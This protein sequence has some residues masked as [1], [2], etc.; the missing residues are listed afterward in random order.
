MNVFAANDPTST[1]DIWS[2]IQTQIQ[3]SNICVF[4]NT[5]NDRRYRTNQLL[6]LVYEKMKPDKLIVRGENI[7]AQINK[8][9]QENPE[10][11]TICL[12]NKINIKEMM[13]EFSRLNN[14]FIVGIGNM[15]GWG[16]Q[17]ISDLKSYR[18]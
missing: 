10:I 3:K 11:E 8:Y 16:E 7:S 4:L 1:L 2:Q 18:I 12:P 15:V 17:F 13:F 5:R 9:Q 14:F 6:S